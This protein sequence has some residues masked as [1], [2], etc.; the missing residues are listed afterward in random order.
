M[1]HPNEEHKHMKALKRHHD[2][3]GFVAY[4]ECGMMSSISVNHGSS[5][6]RKRLQC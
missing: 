1:T 4:A 3:L 6:S 2:M 5:V